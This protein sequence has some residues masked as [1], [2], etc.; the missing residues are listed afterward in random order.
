[1]GQQ[2]VIQMTGPQGETVVLG[3]TVVAKNAAFQPGQRPGN[4]IDIS[5]PY[6]ATLPQKIAMILQ[7]GGP[8]A[9]QQW[10]QLEQELRPFGVIQAGYFYKDLIDPIVSVYVPYSTVNPDGSPDLAAQNVNAEL[11]TE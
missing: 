4:G 8:E 2:T 5:M 3:N 1:M 11:Q 9:L 6:A 10:R 7:Q